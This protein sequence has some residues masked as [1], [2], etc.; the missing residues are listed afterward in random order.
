MYLQSFNVALEDGF[1]VMRKSAKGNI[2]LWNE[3]PREINR[4]NKIS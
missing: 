2:I 1:I 4:S 3:A